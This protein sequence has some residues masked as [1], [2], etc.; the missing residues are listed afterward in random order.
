[1]KVSYSKSK[2]TTLYYLS[3][4]IW[5]NGKSTTKTIEFLGSDEDIRKREGVEDAYEWAKQYA[6]ERTKQEKEAHREII[7]KYSPAK[8]I[9]K[10]EQRSV[11]IGYLFLQ[12][13]YYE[14]GLNKICSEIKKK[15]KFTY[16]LN[17]ILS[18]LVYSRILFPASKRR[19]L[20]DARCFLEAP[21]I[22]LQHMYRGLEYLC[23]ENDLI[24]AS[25]YKN[26]L[27][28]TERKNHVLYY[29]CTNY[30]FEIESDDE[31]RKYGFSKENRPNPIVQMGLF[32]DGDGIP[33]SF[34]IFEGNKNEQGSMTPLEQK[35]MSD[36]GLKQF[37]VCTDSGLSSLANRKFNNVSNRKYIT[38]QSIKKLK[39]FLQ[40]FC[41]GDD[42]WKLPGSKKEYKISE[43]DAE[44]DFD[45]VF[46]KERWINEDGL[47]QRLIVTFSLKYKNYQK[48][49]RDRQVEKAAKATNASKEHFRPNDYKRFIEDTYCTDD[50]EIASNKKR[51]VDTK[52]VQNEEK[53]DGFYAVCTNLKDDASAIIAVNHRR[54]EIEECF[55]IMKTEFKGRPVYLSRRDRI[56]AHFLTCFISLIVY[57]I[58]EKKLKDKYTCEDII[59]T[60]RSMG[61][62]VADTEGYIPEY[63]RTDLTDD[64]HEAFGFRTDYQIVS[65]KE[66]KK[67]CSATK[68]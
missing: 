18:C 62:L 53:Y 28:V 32:M 19:T 65:K 59:R 60:L 20:E 43:L 66:M 40:D 36:F 23:R 4:S 45:K 54:W 35:I 10:D 21:S 17:S 58:L 8:Q 37:V 68:K 27:K 1:L 56:T 33:L 41:L 57:R 47:E 67:I 3:K 5:V 46:Y 16:D 42:K 63:T 55:R 11:N 15:Y 2:N 12:D 38:V 13:I 34:T 64:L 39:A 6:R 51:S 7:L 14:L 31:F 9:K 26:S 52:K 29:D 25:L 48:T 50:G 44:K 24:Q 49:I 61:M 30:Y 22:D